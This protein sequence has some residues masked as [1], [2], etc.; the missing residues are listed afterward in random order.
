VFNGL[1]TSKYQIKIA[2]NSFFGE[3]LMKK[4]LEIFPKN[5]FVGVY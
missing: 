4:R 1:L 3:Y 2:Q 5:I